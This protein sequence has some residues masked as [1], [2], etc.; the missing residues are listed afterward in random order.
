MSKGVDLSHLGIKNYENREVL[1]EPNDGRHAGCMWNVA[2]APVNRSLSA[3]LPYEKCDEMATVVRD[4]SCRPPGYTH[5]V[6]VIVALCPVHNAQISEVCRHCKGIAL[7]RTVGECGPCGGTGFELLDGAIM[8][9]D[10]ANV[11]VRE[12][13]GRVA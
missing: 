1:D 8:R 10:W 5:N 4:V 9:I 2:E 6:D 7:Y 3:I 11:Q 12:E 13:G